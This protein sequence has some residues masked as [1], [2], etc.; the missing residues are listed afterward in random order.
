MRQGFFVE[1]L[2][3]SKSKLYGADISPEMIKY[4]QERVGNYAELKVSDSDNLPWG[5]NTFD[6]IVCILSFHHY[7][8]PEKSLEEMKRVLKNNGHITIAELWIPAPLRYLT[9]LYMKSNLIEQ[10]MSKFI[11]KMNGLICL[12]TLDL[13][14]L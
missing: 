4:A 13:L 6:I 7:P 5:D 3:E 2:K 10:V 14:I 12:K 8:T 9:N 11:Q 1:L